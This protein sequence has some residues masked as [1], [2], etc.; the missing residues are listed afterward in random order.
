MMS[1]FFA[2][3]ALSLL[4]C[5]TTPAPYLSKPPEEE[6][7]VFFELDGKVVVKECKN[8]FVTTDRLSCKGN[9]TTVEKNDFLKSVQSLIEITDQDYLKPYTQDEFSILEKD[10]TLKHRFDEAREKRFLKK[11]S[12]IKTF[13]HLFAPEYDQ[14]TDPI[15]VGQYIAHAENDLRTGKKVSTSINGLNL[16][17]RDL[18]GKILSSNSLYPHSFSKSMYQF[19]SPA[20]K[21]Y[22]PLILRP[23]GLKGS[24]EERIK[25]CWRVKHA[26]GLDWFLVSRFPTGE[27]VWTTGRADSFARSILH[28]SSQGLTLRR[29]E[30]ITSLDSFNSCVGPVINYV[31]KEAFRSALIK[32]LL[33]E[34]ADFIPTYSRNEIKAYEITPE[35]QAQR[36]E[37][38]S[39]AIEEKLFKVFNFLSTFEPTQNDNYDASG[40]ELEI[41]LSRLNLNA[42]HELSSHVKGLNSRINK[43]V[44]IISSA[45]IVYP[46]SFYKKQD[47]IL[48]EK[49]TWLDPKMKPECGLVGA[50]ENR[51]QNCK[52][53]VRVDTYNWNLVSR[54]GAQELWQDDA[55]KVIWSSE[56]PETMNQQNAL[57][58][59]YH[60]ELEKNHGEVPSL[61]GWR[62]AEL[63]GLRGIFP[64]LEN[65]W[66]W[67]S[68]L[69]SSNRAISVKFFEKD[70]RIN[71]DYRGLT[72]TTVHC[73][74]RPKDFLK[75]EGT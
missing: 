8:Y 10:L 49:I 23:C 33:F 69:K 3:V 64:S 32:D 38:R 66:S 22:E 47:D 31:S 15:K 1:R 59:C 26:E 9:E 60:Q 5:S 68:T 45:K 65:H 51:I 37:I 21:T 28:E 12:S 57:K 44:D 42:G 39:R 54:S 16:Y 4:A 46:L 20:L 53:T 56:Q 50:I 62:L 17:T 25:D 55:T 29:C 58:S 73:I 52:T 11:I 18:L 13:I 24:Q 72:S 71:T 61:E 19:F 27:T 6:L 75:P 7:I 67:S 41:I 48:N 74:F 63:H 14:S 36:R 34:K 35:L 30:N 43:V 40:L 70:S 2:L